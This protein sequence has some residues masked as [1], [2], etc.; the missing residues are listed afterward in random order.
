[1]SA[2]EN[3]FQEHLAGELGMYNS[4]NWQ[5]GALIGSLMMN[6]EIQDVFNATVLSCMRCVEHFAEVN[7]EAICSCLALYARELRRRGVPCFNCGKEGSR[8]CAGCRAAIFCSE[9]CQRAQWDSHKKMCKI[10]SQ[11]EAHFK[12]NNISVEV[13]PGVV[14]GGAQGARN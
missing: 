7:V 8:A 2:I 5:Q 3:L 12:E 4:S 6:R 9:E 11:Y 10:V 14:F 1:M 13:K